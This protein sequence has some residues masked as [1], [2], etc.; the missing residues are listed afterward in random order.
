MHPVEKLA[1]QLN[2]T[3]KAQAKTVSKAWKTEARALLKES[4]ELLSLN[5]PDEAAL[6]LLEKRLNSQ[7]AM[8]NNAA[9]ELTK[10]AKTPKP[11]HRKTEPNADLAPQKEQQT[12]DIKAEIDSVTAQAVPQT[13]SPIDLRDDK[14]EA[15][16]SVAHSSYVL[17]KPKDKPAKPSQDGEP[18]S[19]G[20]F[21]MVRVE[22]RQ[23]FKIN[24][25]LPERVLGRASAYAERHSEVLAQRIEAFI[26]V[27]SKSSE[28]ETP[29]TDLRTGYREELIKDM[30]ERGLVLHPKRKK[31]S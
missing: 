15:N 17:E 3:L 28:A 4:F 14:G 2:A 26:A 19:I 21:E 22:I 7:I 10:T 11:S 20:Y 27:L 23:F 1:F 31:K 16:D 9:I 5:P 18:Q 29:T 13:P 8:A 6:N 30:P 24:A 25:C 12:Q